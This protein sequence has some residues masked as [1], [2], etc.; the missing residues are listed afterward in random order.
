MRAAMQRGVRKLEH[1][2]HSTRSSVS[3]WRHKTESRREGEG[4][5]TRAYDTASGKR[6][7]N[8]HTRMFV[9]HSTAFCDGLSTDSEDD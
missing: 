3:E 6:S 4:S 5:A 1:Q 7:L 9:G 2:Y 8:A